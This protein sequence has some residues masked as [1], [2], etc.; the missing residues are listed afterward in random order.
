MPSLDNIFPNLDELTKIEDNLINP[1][2]RSLGDNDL[3]GYQLEYAYHDMP[4]PVD[5]QA[6]MERRGFYI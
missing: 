5:L 6:E 2:W 4:L 3:K 1:D